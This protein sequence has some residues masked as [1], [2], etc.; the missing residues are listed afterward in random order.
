MS[1]KLI[2][3]CDGNTKIQ[4][5]DGNTKIQLCEPEPEPQDCPEDCSDCPNL[6]TAVVSDVIGCPTLDGTYLVSAAGC[7]WFSTPMIIYCNDG[8]WWCLLSVSGGDVLWRAPNTAGCP[9]A[10]GWIR[11]SGSCEGGSLTL[12]W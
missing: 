2:Q 7:D 1:E 3:L 4:L 8:M 12:S 11:D 5:C 6:I 10:T 9:P